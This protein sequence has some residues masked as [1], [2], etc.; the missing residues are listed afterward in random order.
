MK[1]SPVPILL[2]LL[3]LGAGLG[4]CLRSKESIHLALDGSGRIDQV[5]LLDV[6][7]RASLVKALA[8]LYDVP[9]A[10]CQRLRCDPLAAG[11]LRARAAGTPGYRL[12]LLE[13]SEP[14]EETGRRTVVQGVFTSLADAAR[15]AW[16]NRAGQGAGVPDASPEGRREHRAGDGV[17]HKGHRHEWRTRH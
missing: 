17:P 10:K 1:A 7:G 5:V 6:E 15:G 11:W 12:S 13:V 4:G 9:E 3:L 16:G 8:D 2:L 14:K